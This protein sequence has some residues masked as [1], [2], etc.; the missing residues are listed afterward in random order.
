MPRSA[1]AVRTEDP[2]LQHI[3]RLAYL[4]DDS[5]PVPG[6]GRFGVDALIDLIPGV[7]DAAGSV[8][9]LYIMGRAM[10]LGVPRSLLLR[11]AANVGIDTVV[12]AIPFIGALFDAGWKAN[13]R[14]ARLL[15]RYLENPTGEARASKGFLVLLIVVLL[16]LLGGAITLTVF[17]LGGLMQRLW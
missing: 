12:G 13:S 1:P 7:G 6:I 15:T 5:I 14:N 3:R 11:M 4:L 8:I 10:R 16:L 17:L 9:S 2:E